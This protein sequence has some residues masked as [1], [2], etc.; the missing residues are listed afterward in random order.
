MK[1]L[2]LCIGN[3]EYKNMPRLCGAV[4]DAKCISLKLGDL[5]FEV[6][7]LSNLDRAAMVDAITD[8]VDR[9]EDYDSALFYYAGHGCQIEGENILAP[10]DLD[11]S[12]R[13]AAIK[14]N[15]FPLED[16]MR[17]LDKYP[18]K[19]KIFIFDACRTILFDRGSVKG[20][21]PVLA[22]QGSIIAFS[23]SPGQLSSE[24]V[25]SQ[26]GYYT[27]TLLNYIKLPRVNIETIFKKTREQL[28][29]VF[30]GK[31]IPWEHTS[32][33]GD[34]FLNPNTIYD[35]VNYSPE[36]LADSRYN[37][38]NSYVREIIDGLKSHNWYTQGAV[39]SRISALNFKEVMASDLFVIGRNIYQSAD[40][41]CFDAQSY[42]NDFSNKKIPNEAKL[43]L[44][45]GIA[46]EIYFTSS[47]TL[48]LHPKTGYYKPVIQLLEKDEFYGSKAFI[49]SVLCKIDNQILYIPGQNES[50]DFIAETDD[51]H[52]LQSIT[53]KGINVLFDGDGKKYN[54]DIEYPIEYTID[55]LINEI[56]RQVAAPNDCVILRGLSSEK[57]C[58]PSSFTLRKTEIIERIDYL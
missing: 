39:L 2:A 55:Q 30:G 45:N 23:T 17:S 49:T 36:A 1:R 25:K 31:Q 51:K 7:C 22:P 4:N 40:G 28:V 13:L 44:L 16:L 26:H 37:S 10:T 42:I 46:Y 35:G 56:S 58:F 19:V 43:H 21:A 6:I 29:A 18:D 33:V 52:R 11:I 57:V 27:E 8:F 32:L 20:F 54:F 5:G 53:Y 9:I 15:A 3:D 24:N 48:R 34:Y 38:R 41:S 47:N 12:Q 50:M 14:Y